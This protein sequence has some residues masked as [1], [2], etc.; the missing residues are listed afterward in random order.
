VVLAGGFVMRFVACSCVMAF[1]TCG[2]VMT[3][4]G[5]MG[6]FMGGFMSNT[7]GNL[8]QLLFGQILDFFCVGLSLFG[9]LEH[10]RVKSFHL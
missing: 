3:F 2:R 4:A 9:E 5:M 10:R 1:V 7:T 8:E 6:G